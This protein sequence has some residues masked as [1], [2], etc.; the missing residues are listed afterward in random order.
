MDNH[1]FFSYLCVSDRLLVAGLSQHLRNSPVR[2]VFVD[3]WEDA[4]VESLTVRGKISSFGVFSFF[5][6]WS[7]L[8]YFFLFV[9][10]CKQCCV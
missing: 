2:R 4:A 8:L 7:S 6:R 3:E 9:R 5:G 10:V 1:G